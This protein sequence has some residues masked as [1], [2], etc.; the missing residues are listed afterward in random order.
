MRKI[1]AEQ[2][3]ELSLLSQKVDKGIDKKGAL[4]IGVYFEEGINNA[5]SIALHH[6]HR[7]QRQFVL[8][9]IAVRLCRCLGDV[10][11]DLPG[12]FEGVRDIL[13]QFR[14]VGLEKLQKFR[15]L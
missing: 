7:Q 8:P 2:R 12:N 10:P 1:S 5:G 6:Q 9:R 4:G 3:K 13:E 14:L 11:Y 15:V